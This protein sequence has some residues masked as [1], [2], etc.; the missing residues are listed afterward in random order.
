MR[1]TDQILATL[2]VLDRIHRLPDT[3][4]LTT[5][6]AAVFLRSSVSALEALRASGDGPIYMQGGAKGTVGVNQKCLYEKADLLAWQRSLKVVSVNA[7][8]RRKGQYFAR[9]SDLTE[10]EAFWVDDRGR[11]LEMVERA[12][13]G[14][15]VARLGVFDIVWLPCID[16][17]S[18]EWSNVS[19]HQAFARDVESTLLGE[20]QRIHAGLDASDLGSAIE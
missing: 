20:I 6:E 1:S 9:L 10:T 7:A 2:E 8:G 13:I 12:T 11:V 14:R 16:A 18:R 5:S 3:V 15:A 17:A 4:A 19:E